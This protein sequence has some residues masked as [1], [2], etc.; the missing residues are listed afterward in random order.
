MV[1]TISFIQTN[2]QHSISA[3]G[4]LTRTV[5]VKGMNV[6]LVQ[7]PW[8]RE[9]CI[10]GLT[11]PGYTLYFAG[12]KERPRACILARNRNACVLPDFSCRDLVAI[13]M[14]YNEDAAERRLVVCSAYLPYDS[15]DRA[16]SR[17]MEVLVRYC[18]KENLSL[19]VGCDS[20]ALH[21]DWGST[22]CNGRGESLLQFLSSS[23][24]GILNRG[25]EPMFGNVPRQEV[26]DITLGSYGLLESITRWEVSREPFLSGHRHILFT[27]RGS[28]PALLISNPRGT[29]WGT[30]RGDLTDKLERGPELSMQDE[31]G[32]GLP[33]QWIQQTLV[34][35]YEENCPIRPNKNGRIS[36]KWTPELAPLRREVIQLFIRYR[37]DNKSSSWELYRQAQRRYR[38]EVRKASKETWRNFC[39]SIKHISRS[40]R[41]HR[42][43]SRDPKT[44]LRERTQSEG[45]PWISYLLLT[46]PNRLL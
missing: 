10:R 15:E 43:L 31:A 6:V 17:E 7:E 29:N 5:G 20:N 8:Y 1:S 34:T 27:L 46:S 16:R 3:S 41:L 4:I 25:N 30:L 13:L 35:V 32:L 33:V 40:A 36:L 18:E 45:K 21:T 28:V 26:I 24:L 12:G 19:T 9:D 22:S 11:V 37:A 2:L 42:S 38:E 14:K 23:N 39:G 44:K